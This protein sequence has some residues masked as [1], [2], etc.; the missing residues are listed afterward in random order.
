LAGP[1][2]IRHIRA[3]VH[4]LDMSSSRI[5]SLCLGLNAGCCFAYAVLFGFMQTKLLTMYG[6]ESDMKSWKKSGAW[7][8]LAQIMRVVGAFEFLMSFLYFHYIGFVDKHK[9][10]LRVGV[11]QYALLASVSAYRV[12]FEPKLSATNVRVAMKSLVVQ[13]VFL[14]VSVVG[15]IEAPPPPKRK[16]A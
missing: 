1:S 16:S 8:V 7:D 13:L 5:S 14:A 4:T 11:M 10:G 3:R 6:V 12:F 15:M 9:A 2:P